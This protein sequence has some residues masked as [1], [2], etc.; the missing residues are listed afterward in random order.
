M[1]VVGIALHVVA[2]GDIITVVA[3]VL[4]GIDAG[5]AHHLH[6]LAVGRGIVAR[7]PELAAVLYARDEV[8]YLLLFG[9]LA[10]L[11][12]LRTGDVLLLEDAAPVVV[13]YLYQVGDGGVVLQL[14]HLADGDET[15][16]VIPFVPEDGGVVGHGI[17]LAARGREAGNDGEDPVLAS[18]LPRLSCLHLAV[19]AV[20]PHALLQVAQRI[21]LVEQR[22]HL[23][24]GWHGGISPVGIEHIFRASV[25][26]LGKPAVARLLVSYRHNLVALLVEHDG[27]YAEEEILHVGNLFQKE[28]AHRVVHPEQVHLPVLRRQLGLDVVILEAHSIAGEHVEEFVLS[29]HAAPA[30]VADQ[31]VGQLV[32]VAEGYIGIFLSPDFH[33]DDRRGTIIIEDCG[34]LRETAR[35]R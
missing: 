7:Y 35:G 8:A 22:Q 2:L 6:L 1:D 21:Q 20:Q 3:S 28:A 34:R 33:A 32:L 29:H 9:K 18:R 17:V 30:N 24:V 4:R 13:V 19:L 12:F 11:L 26:A 23:Y 15:G 10:L 16:D 25:H 5:D 31:F 27:R 14:R